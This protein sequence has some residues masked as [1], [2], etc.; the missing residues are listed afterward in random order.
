MSL[1]KIAWRSIQQ[2]ALASGLTAF[3]M[4]LGVAL[5]V[6]VLVI[7]NVIDQSFR[8]GSQGYDMIVGAKGGKL[9]L[10]LNTVFHMSEPIENIPYSYYREFSDGRFAN[11]VEAAIPVCMGH[12]YKECQVVATTP[13]MFE[14][15]TY[16][17]DQKY[18]FAEGHN[19]HLDEPF[20]AV[21]GSVA[22]KKAKLG[23]GDTFQPVHPGSVEAEEQKADSQCKDDHH[24]P[25]KI[26]GVLKHTGTPNDGAI[27]MNME[28]FFRFGCHSGGPTA[29]EQFMSKRKPD[30]EAKPN[31]TEAKKTEAAHSHQHASEKS[32]P[33]DSGGLL[34]PGLEDTQDLIHPD[35][36]EHAGEQE[37][38]D[39]HVHGPDCNHGADCKIEVTAEH[40]HGPGCGHDHEIADKDKQ[41]TAIL[42]CTDMSKPRSA[43]VLPDVINGEEVAQAVMPTRVITELFDGIVGNVQLLLM[44]LAVLVVVVAGVGILVSIYNSMSDRRHEIAV[45]RALGASRVTVGTIILM[46]SIML[47][48]GGGLFGLAV[49]H[50]LVGALAPTIAEQTGVIVGAFQFQWQELILIPGLLVLATLV[51]YLPAMSAYRTDV[52]K[53]LAAGQ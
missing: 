4:G 18:E 36:H 27:F 8:R 12:A 43:M 41:I 26:V 35:V 39:V 16:M 15:L 45:M 2:R 21:I 44:I 33:S 47:S 24:Q 23:L 6:S 48:L 42:V 11:A 5:V 40:V 50:A 14:D 34:L 19:F 9:Q 28:G 29:T 46:E 1:W 38:A 49:G 31:K 37:Q 30:V 51:G 3:G 17:G 22:S 52:A 20:T 13:D 7:H 25:I 32:K 53:S 10:V